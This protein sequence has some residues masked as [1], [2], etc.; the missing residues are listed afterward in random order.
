MLKTNIYNSI[1]TRQNPNAYSNDEIITM[2]KIKKQTGDLEKKIN[3]FKQ[4][5]G[6]GGFGGHQ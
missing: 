1:V 5:R 2:L 6:K 3:R 4:D